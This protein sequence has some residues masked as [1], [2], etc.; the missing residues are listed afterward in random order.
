MQ[1]INNSCFVQLQNVEFLEM[2]VCSMSFD[3]ALGFPKIFDAKILVSQ[4]TRSQ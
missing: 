3:E 2:F 1:V 4:V